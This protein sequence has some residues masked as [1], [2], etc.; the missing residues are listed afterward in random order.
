MRW[1]AKGVIFQGLTLAALASN[2]ARTP[3]FLGGVYLLNFRL[4]ATFAMGL[5]SGIVSLTN[6]MW[7]AIRPK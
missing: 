2:I 3:I 5:A 6:V 4:Y 1:G 7:P